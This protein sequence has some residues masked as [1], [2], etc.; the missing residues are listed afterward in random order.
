MTAFLFICKPVFVFEVQYRRCSHHKP[1]LNLHT[2]NSFATLWQ[3]AG[4]GLY[5]NSQLPCGDL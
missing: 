3:L 4:A 1:V 5:C 2:D